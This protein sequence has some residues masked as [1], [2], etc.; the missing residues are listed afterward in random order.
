MLAS[1]GS[2]L[3]THGQVYVPDANWLL[4]I[5]SLSILIGFRDISTIANA[6]GIALDSDH[7]FTSVG[8]LALSS[9]VNLGL[10]G[11][12]YAFVVTSHKLFP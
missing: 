6:T 4:M 8:F 5:L 7:N 2:K 11:Q 10:L 1:R 3:S 12:I 9:R